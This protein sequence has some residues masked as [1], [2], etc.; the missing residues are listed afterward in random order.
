[1]TDLECL[2]S[3]KLGC[4][5]QMLDCKKILRSFSVN[6]ELGRDI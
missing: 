4:V 6:A 1:M 2:K 3:S 5:A